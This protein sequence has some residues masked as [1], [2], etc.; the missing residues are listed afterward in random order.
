MH[1]EIVYE[2]IILNKV[3]D[4][5]TVERTAQFFFLTT[6]LLTRK[7]TEIVYKNACEMDFCVLFAYW[8]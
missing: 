4:C 7:T 1:V 5:L 3:V 6:E 8:L 2:S